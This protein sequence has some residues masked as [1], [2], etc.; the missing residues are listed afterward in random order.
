MPS[1]DGEHTPP[2][3][4]RLSSVWMDAVARCSRDIQGTAGQVV[5]K[6]GPAGRALAWG[7]EDLG[8]NTSVKQAADQGT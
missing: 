4:T 7:L 1:T 3:G 8:S 2:T 5:E 6:C